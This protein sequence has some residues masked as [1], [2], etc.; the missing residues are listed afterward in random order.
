LR[1]QADGLELSE[2]PDPDAPATIEASDHEEIVVDLRWPTVEGQS[3]RR[4]TFKR[5]T[6]VL[7]SV[8]VGPELVVS[9][10]IGASRTIRPKLPRERPM[11]FL[12]GSKLY[13][14][15][16]TAIDLGWS[17]AT[18]EKTRAI[19]LDAVFVDEQA[20]DDLEHAKGL[21][22]MIELVNSP[23]PTFLVSTATL[24]R[25][26]TPVTWFEE[27]MK[28]RQQRPD[29][30]APLERQ[31]RKVL[32][33][34]D[35][36][37]PGDWLANEKR[38]RP[39]HEGLGA[40]PYD[41]GT[42]FRV[43]APGADH[44]AL[45]GD[46]NK[47]SAAHP[48]EAEDGGNWYLDVPGVHPGASYKYGITSS[49]TS[50]LRNDP[51]ARAVSLE[52]SSIVVRAQPP[53]VPFTPARLNDLIVYQLH[54]GT[55]GTQ[56]GTFGIPTAGAGTFDSV[57][58]A[59]AYLRT[60]GVNAVQ[61]LPVAET[62]SDGSVG[63]DPSFPFAVRDKYGGP[64]GL[65]ALVETAHKHRIAVLVDVVFD[66]VAAD[67]GLWQFDGASG[68]GS[69]FASD[70][71]ADSPFGRRLDYGRPEVRQYIRD[72]ALMW[73]EE[74]GVDGLH[75]SG[76]NWIR[77]SGRGQDL[78]DGWTLMQSVNREV[79][80]RFPGA[81]LTS[82]G[83]GH[84]DQMIRDVA[85]GGAGFGGD[86]DLGFA[87]LIRRAV[88]FP[89]DASRDM[90]AVASAVNGASSQIPVGRRVIYT[91]SYDVV[92]DRHGG[93]LPE[94]IFPGKAESWYACQ[95][96]SLAAALVFTSP[97]TPL[98]FHGQER[99]T[100]VP[101]RNRVPFEW[102]DTPVTAASLRLYEDLIRLRWVLP[103]LRGPHV[104]VFHVNHS[105]KVIAFHRWSD[106]GDNAVVV[107]NFK[108]W[109][110]GHYV[111]GLPFGGPWQVAFRM[112]RSRF[113]PKA[114]SQ[115]HTEVQGHLKPTH[116]MAFSGDIQLGEYE[117]MVLTLVPE[118]RSA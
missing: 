41:G 85:S 11:A 5:G 6:R 78:P 109:R 60:L 82:E 26:V 18:Y 88:T 51:R 94:K 71:R 80:A 55:F 45:S 9:T 111:I 13:S 99:M 38:S 57:S 96:A 49:G 103:C 8:P 101:F 68:G 65:R 46:F 84:G 20:A 2:P 107:A 91:E 59:M 61:L 37:R 106:D 98:L 64:S 33:E 30:G 74:Y 63:F 76:T 70:W 62:A 39:V 58:N 108:N 21:P 53:Q 14:V 105:N 95:R 3:T 50:A 17:V 79:L 90:D 16:K 86:W 4:E 118:T 116:G 23:V 113:D 10:E 1:L 110:F 25:V 83:E 92:A 56:V 100:S 47:W 15:Q 93:R 19:E 28:L 89:D 31:V 81:L 112:D 75:W 29:L 97:G 36:R 24:S 115:S 22:W 87:S 66:H 27:R 40:L 44:V 12:L 48:M 73:L 7:A 43:W 35:L 34:L 42:A 104:N 32:L 117:L 77:R 72:N 69:Y 102:R 52:S 54:V 67:S 114:T